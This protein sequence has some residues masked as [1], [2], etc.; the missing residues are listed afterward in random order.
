MR[1]RDGPTTHPPEFR[2]H[3]PIYHTKRAQHRHPVPL[4]LLTKSEFVPTA[5]IACKTSSCC[6]TMALFFETTKNFLQHPRHSVL[7]CVQ[8]ADTSDAT[9]EPGMR[10][11]GH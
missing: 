6:S 7:A 10:L 9:S 2:G 3:H 8:A 5:E 4:R 1:W 11:C